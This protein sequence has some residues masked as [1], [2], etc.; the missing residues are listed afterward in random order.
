[1]KALQGRIF[2]LTKDPYL[3]NEEECYTFLEQGILILDDDGIIM[4]VGEP[5]TLLPKYANIKIEYYDESCLIVPGFIDA[6][7]HYP[8]L[9]IIGAYG[10]QL[11]DW[12]NNYTFIAEQNF[13]NKDYARKIACFFIHELLRNGVTT[14]A[15]YATVYAGSADALFKEASAVNFNMI[16][17]KI[18]MSRNAPDKLIEKPQQSFEDTKTLI[19][20]WHKNGRNKYAITPRFAIT[21]PEEELEMAGELFKNTEGLF[22]QTHLSENNDEIAFT[23]ELFP[24]SKS[25]TEVYEKYNLLGRRALFG[26]G[27]HLSPKELQILSESESTIVHCPTSNMFLGSGLLDIESCKD[28]SRPIYIGLGSDVGAGTSLSPLQTLNEAYKVA[29]L[30]KQAMSAIK[31]FYILTLGN[32]ESLDLAHEVGTFKKGLVGDITVLQT[33]G[34]PLMKFRNEYVKNIIEELFVQMTIGDDRSIKATYL[35][36]NKVY[37]NNTIKN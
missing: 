5:S 24:K 7:V 21:C 36:G 34:T 28:P 20:K 14:A 22:M 35:A 8:Q 27:I 13:S 6:H 3:Y 9:E 11:L 26:H 16:G 31:A 32:A 15:T 19:N 29:Q 12:L 33:T 1:M 25:Y 37:H 23:L 10:K 18:L 17:G 2:Y 4:D 30:Q